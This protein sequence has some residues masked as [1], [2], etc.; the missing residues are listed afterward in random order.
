MKDKNDEAFPLH[1]AV[2]VAWEDNVET[3]IETPT[4][5]LRDYEM[6]PFDTAL[7]DL[8]G[9]FSDPGV[10]WSPEEMKEAVLMAKTT[11]HREYDDPEH[12]SFEPFVPSPEKEAP[13]DYFAQ[14][15]V[16]N[17]EAS[18]EQL[19]VIA[20]RKVQ[21]LTEKVVENRRAKLNKRFQDKYGGSKTDIFENFAFKV[22]DSVVP[23]PF[24][25]EERLRR[26]KV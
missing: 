8:S 24:S 3:L 25:R 14:D 20:L 26:Q 5:D 1:R 15:I 16:K 2:L 13:W 21:L 19:R 22:N 7:A 12:T 10:I 23:P 11:L 9:I 18:E 4:S 6:L 17:D